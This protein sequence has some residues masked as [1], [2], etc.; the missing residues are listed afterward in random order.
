ML[1]EGVLLGL[2]L[3]LMV[4]PLFFAIVQAALEGGLRAGI[5]LAMGMWSSDL[6]FVLLTYFGTS[7]LASFT[8]LPH[9]RLWAGLL[10]GILLI[11]FGISALLAQS[12]PKLKLVAAKLPGPLYS[13]F[14]RGFLLNTVNPFTLFFWLSIGSGIVAINRGETLGLVRFFL[15]MLLTLALA[16]LLKAWGA[17]YLRQ[18][19]TPPHIRRVQQGIGILLIVFGIVLLSRSAG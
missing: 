12:A 2:T 15:G 6:L 8:A 19:L 7:V 9:F 4:G 16:D 3:S 1:I 5:A 13:Y 18:W 10:G 17:K 11:A 14:L